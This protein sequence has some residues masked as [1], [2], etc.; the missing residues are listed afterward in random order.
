MH[1]TEVI[2]GDI[3]L[4]SLVARSFNPW[5][6]FKGKKRGRRIRSQTFDDD[7]ADEARKK[8]GPRLTKQVGKGAD[9][10]R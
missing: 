6:R 9:S 3:V 1:S 5:R 2:F 4:G 8:V 10:P 7:E